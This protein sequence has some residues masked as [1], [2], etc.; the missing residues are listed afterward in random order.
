VPDASK[1]IFV[2]SGHQCQTVFNI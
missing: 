1:E 2:S